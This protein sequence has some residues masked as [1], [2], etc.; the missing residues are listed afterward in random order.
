[1]GEW[2]KALGEEG[3]RIASF[4]FE[5]ILGINS[6]QG[7]ASISCSHPANH[8]RQES[9]GDK[10]LT[11][12]IDGLYYQV[13]PLED[14]LLDVVIISTKYCDLYPTNPKGKF[15][16]DF[17]ELAQTIECFLSSKSNS[18]IQGS[19][20]SVS[21]TA[22]TGILVW[23]SSKDDVWKNI[24]PAV[25]SAYFDKDIEFEKIILVDN[26]RVS[27]W[28]ESIYKTRKYYDDVQIVYHNSG[29]NSVSINS[30]SFGT[31]VPVEYLFSDV[32]TFRVKKDGIT[33]LVIYVND[34]FEQE[35]FHQMVS[36]AK[37]FDHLHMVDRIDFQFRAYNVS[38]HENQVRAS[39][40][41]FDGYTLNKNLFINEFPENFRQQS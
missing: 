17:I 37:V 27:F 23:L 10:R 9:K 24:K 34:Q 16:R 6:L 4:V 32:L 7:R 1:M 25:Q 5:E 30:K 29:L 19:V 14:E 11:H 2:S 36:F 12:G 41:H 40:Q 26:N 31:V 33:S 38:D 13:S 3:E 15:K 35:G 8:V 28:Y 39:L 20:S 18:D 21:K 22:Y